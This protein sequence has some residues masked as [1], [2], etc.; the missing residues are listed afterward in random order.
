MKAT[1][2]EKAIASMA[3]NIK[4]ITPCKEVVGLRKD[5]DVIYAGAIL[6]GVT[7][8]GEGIALEFEPYLSFHNINK[9]NRPTQEEYQKC[10]SICKNYLEKFVNN[11]FVIKRYWDDHLEITNLYTLTGQKV[12]V[13]IQSGFNL[14]NLEEIC[15]GLES[16][17]F[18]FRNFSWDKTHT[19]YDWFYASSIE[20]CE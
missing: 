7:S 14:S 10:M 19:K 11:D 9:Q 17:D 12:P 6:L 2:R 13:T 3:G 15:G 5:Q 1:E 18:K 16:H 20:E 4:I 8:K